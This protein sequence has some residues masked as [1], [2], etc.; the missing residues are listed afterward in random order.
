MK[1][2]FFYRGKQSPP[3]EVDENLTDEELNK[4]AEEWMEQIHKK[5]RYSVVDE[6]E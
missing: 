5:A 2:K 1:V 6:D 3:I 4:M